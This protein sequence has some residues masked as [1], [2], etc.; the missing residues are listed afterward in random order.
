MVAHQPRYSLFTLFD[1]VLLLGKG[2]R[3]AYL[4]PP[5]GARAYF[6]GL[7]FAAPALENPADW[8]MDVVSGDVPQATEAGCAVPDAAAADMRPEMLFEAWR[9]KQAANTAG[10]EDCD[11]ELAGCPLQRAG[12]R[13][14]SAADDRAVLRRKLEEGWD[15]LVSDSDGAMDP[16]DLRGVLEYCSGQKP[17]HGVVSELMRQMTCPGASVVTRMQFLNHFCSLGRLAIAEEE[18]DDAARAG[19]SPH[20]PSTNPRVDAAGMSLAAALALQGL[21]RDTPGF[22]SQY[23]V[24]LCR[25]SIQWWRMTRQR[26]LFLGALG[27][28]GIILAVL[29]RWV[30]VVP[31]WSAASLFN[32]HTCLALLLSIFSLQVFA[33]D[34]H[35][36]WRES[37]SGISVP[38]FFLSRLH[39]STVDIVL[40]TVVFTANYFVVR[41][42]RV[43]FTCF[44]VPFLLT[45]FASSGWG[46][47]VSTVVQPKHGPFVVSLIIFIVCGVLGDPADLQNFLSGGVLEVV[48]NSLSITRWSV[49]MGFN[50]DDWCLDPQPLDPKGKAVLSM[51][52]GVFFS[53]SFFSRQLVPAAALVAMGTGLRVASFLALRDMNRHRQI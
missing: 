46:Y 50:Y 5:R 43:D 25:R 31:R 32:L 8:V 37:A 47:F 3:T 49:Q 44:V 45:A 52:R 7:G 1:D 51:A 9:A 11:C 21:W 20:T 2:G 14:M 42:P 22:Y 26:A 15:Q 13:G 23:S 40:M 38:A 28:G 36:F 30:M 16:Q 4:G 48:V 34:Q 10:I 12:S 27:L 29:D 33:N 39:M 6:E 35:I 19:P 24:L 18:D 17:S 41:Q 53:D